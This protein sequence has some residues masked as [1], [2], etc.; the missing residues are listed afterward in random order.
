MTLDR[1]RLTTG[2]KADEE[3]RWRHRVN[4]FVVWLGGQAGP[5]LGGGEGLTKVGKRKRSGF[6]GFGLGGFYLPK[7]F[8]IDCE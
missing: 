1:S 7:G 8:E 2:G 6:E 3:Q 4:N 5:D